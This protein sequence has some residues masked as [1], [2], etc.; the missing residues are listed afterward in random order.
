MALVVRKEN[1]AEDNFIFFAIMVDT[2]VKTT[3]FVVVF[4]VQ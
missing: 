1:F 2:G 3:N 4:D